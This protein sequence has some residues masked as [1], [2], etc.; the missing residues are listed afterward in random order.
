MTVPVLRH[1]AAKK[2]I[3]LLSQMTILAVDALKPNTNV[4]L[5]FLVSWINAKYILLTGADNYIG[6]LLTNRKVRKTLRPAPEMAPVWVSSIST[7]LRMTIVPSKRFHLFL[8]YSFK[9]NPMSLS[10]ISKKKTVVKI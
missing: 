4:T 9:P 10:T 1:E 5:M 2:I 8:Q 3:A 7:K 6:S